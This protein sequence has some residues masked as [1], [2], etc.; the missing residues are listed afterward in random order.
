[1][2]MECLDLHGLDYEEAEFIIEKFITDN[3]DDLP[4]KIVSGHSRR[5]SDLIKEVVDRHDLQCHKEMWF[6]DGCWV[7]TDF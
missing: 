3:F 4:I 7:I 1:M 2:I 5:F 6:N